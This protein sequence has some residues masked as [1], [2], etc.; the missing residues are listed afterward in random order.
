MLNFYLY[1]VTSISLTVFYIA[2]VVLVNGLLR[3]WLGVDTGEETRKAIAGGAGFISVSLPMWWIH[4][5]WLR[6]QFSQT[7]ATDITWHRFYLFTIVCLNAM[8]ILI[9]GSIG[10]T[11]LAGI[12][13][14]IGDTTA[15][16]LA[17]AGIALFALLLSGGLW[18]HHW[19]QF[20]GEMG[21]LLP[22]LAANPE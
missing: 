18:L 12:I 5:R 17:N 11:N 14:A 22:R 19:R 8:A 15:K 1:S 20:K 3:L 7:Q 2:A 6:L 16:S 13:L 21:E 4:W 10:V 9:G